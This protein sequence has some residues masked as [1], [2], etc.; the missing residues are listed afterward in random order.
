M[1]ETQITTMDALIYALLRMRSL[2]LAVQVSQLIFAL[3]G[4]AI[5]LWT[6]QALTTKN[7]TMGI[8][9][10]VMVALIHARLR[11]DTLVL[12]LEQHAF[13]FAKTASEI[14]SLDTLNNATMATRSATMAALH[15]QSTMITH[16][17]E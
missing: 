3:T 2:A 9:Q 16:V 17:L 7:A 5:L 6:L 12:L 13:N 8:I 4:V 11:L 14:L 10:Q 15:V 1:T